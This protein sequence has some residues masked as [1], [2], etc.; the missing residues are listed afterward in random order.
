MYQYLP[1]ID[2]KRPSNIPCP[3]VPAGLQPSHPHP[4]SSKRRPAIPLS[5]IKSIAAILPI[6]AEIWVRW[7]HLYHS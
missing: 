7:F 3:I 6:P 1:S 4:F 5:P 2:V